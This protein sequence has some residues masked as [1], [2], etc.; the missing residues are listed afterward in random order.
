[1]YEDPKALR[2]ASRQDARAAARDDF[3]MFYRLIFPALAPEATF[4]DSPHYRVLARAL[5]KVGKGETRRLLIAIPPRHGKS[6]LASVALPAWILGRDPKRKLICGA[7]GEGLSKDFANRFRDLIRSPQYQAIFPNT[8]IDAGGASLSEIRTTER[9]RVSPRDH[10]RR[11]GDR[12]GGWDFRLL[13][14]PSR[15]RRARRNQT[16][17]A[18]SSTTGSKAH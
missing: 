6:I 15:P 14:T 18:T 17:L 12:Q 5:E 8:Q 3:Y 7:H 4:S 2:R 10:G 16:A 9:K 1:M 13:T 11:P